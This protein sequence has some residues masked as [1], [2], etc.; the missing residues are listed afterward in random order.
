MSNPTPTS[1][2]QTVLG[3]STVLKGELS[4]N[5]DLAIEGQLDGSIN[6]QDHC[7]TVGANS[8]VKAEI[9][10][11]SV[12]VH[13]SVEGNVTTREKVDIRK[14]GRVLGDLNAAGI[15]IE[16]GAFFKGKIEIRRVDEPTRVAHT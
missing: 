9:H 12:I 16:D 13:G 6:L 5:E 3:R 1:Q 15:A 2:S 8:Q 10:A 4:A 11:R 7:L 14:S